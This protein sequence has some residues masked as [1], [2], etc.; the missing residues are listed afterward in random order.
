MKR[1]RF[2]LITFIL[3]FVAIEGWG[4][5]YYL[6]N[7]YPSDLSGTGYSVTSPARYYMTVSKQEGTYTR[8]DETF[9]YIYAS[10]RYTTYYNTFQ[11]NISTYVKPT[12]VAGYETMVEYSESD[13]NPFYGV[14]SIYYYKAVG[15]ANYAVVSVPSDLANTG[16]TLTNTDASI[17]YTFE[18][19]QYT[20]SVTGP[21]FWTSGEHKGETV[22]TVDNVPSL[23]ENYYPLCY[24]I[25]SSNV[26][27][28]FTGK[29]IDGYNVSSIS[30]VNVTSTGEYASYYNY[31]RRMI[32]VNYTP[33]THSCYYR[34]QYNDGAPSGADFSLKTTSLEHSTTLTKNGYNVSATTDNNSQYVPAKITQDN[35]DDVIAPSAVEGYLTKTLLSGGTGTSSD[36]YVI[37][38]NYY[39]N[40][41]INGLEYSTLHTESTGHQYTLPE[42]EVAVSIYLGGPVSGGIVGDTY[43]ETETITDMVGYKDGINKNGVQLTTTTGETTADVSDDDGDVAG[44]TASYKCL[45]QLAQ[46]IDGTGVTFDWDYYYERTHEVAVNKLTNV[47]IPSTVTDPV[48][49]GKF[50]VTAIQKFGFVYNASD[51]ND[52]PYCIEGDDGRQI[53][54]PNNINDHRNDYLRSVTFAQPCQVRSIG[55]YAFISC[56][57]LTTFTVPYTVEY[58]GVGTFECSMKL[59]TVNFQTNPDETAEDFGKTRLRTINN[60]TFWFCTGLKSVI[61]ADGIERIEGQPSGSSF[62]YNVGLTYI[63]LPN[64]LQ[65]IGPHFLC[66]ATSIETVTIPA[67]VT[68]ID[69]A[70]FHGCESLRTVYLLGKAAYLKADDGGSCRT[71]DYNETHC[72]DH[73]N[74]CEFYVPADYLNDYKNDAVWSQIDENGDHGY[75][76]SL[77]TI[78]SEKRT[79]TPDVWQTVIFPQRVGNNSQGDGIGVKDYKNVF[80]EGTIVAELTEVHMDKRDHGLYRLTFTEISGDNIP[81]GKPFMI[82]PARETTF[83][84][85]D[86]YDQ[87]DEAFLLDMSDEHPYYQT[88]PEDGTKIFMKGTYI[89]TKM[90]IWDFYLTKKGN[91]YLFRKVPDASFNKSS[92]SCRC[93]W[94][95]EMGGVRANVSGAKAS[96]GVVE[97][98]PTGIGNVAQ[99]DLQ[100]P[101]LVIDGIYDLNG[102]KMSV[103]VESLQKG[104]YIINGKKTVVK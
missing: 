1:F 55:D 96:F 11:N 101:R 5:R 92:A 76:N 48:G 61:L 64:T 40:W 87:A 51:Q 89:P 82:K 54:I 68:Y 50:N 97:E 94:T 47:T 78:V 31:C 98:D 70:C 86:D 53:I 35:V 28:Y 74:H 13:G 72:G 65:Y 8:T 24:P 103:P 56:K 77:K 9:Y 23:G 90:A 44:T 49:G 7:I 43:Y 37:T 63:R 20:S 84:M 71:F 41:V 17:T 57:E 88:A 66:S 22:Y 36:P 18:N 69:G 30:I 83:T 46:N 75:Y 39:R 25:T 16:V 91:D 58:L 100:E 93:W 32:V 26:N 19:K 29:E 10:T 79:F 67:S 12:Q 81:S 60:W 95:I 52:M 99:E 34:V 27:Q 3:S 38:I 42:G 33:K 85:F 80:G 4:Q 6:V 104:I 14:I 73:V 102:R 59:A 21:Y 62:Q 2:I 15:T 45:G